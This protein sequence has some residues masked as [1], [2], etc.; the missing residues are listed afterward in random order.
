VSI[1]GGVGKILEIAGTWEVFYNPVSPDNVSIDWMMRLQL[2][3][4]SPK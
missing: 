3:C 4:L 2:Q 1:G